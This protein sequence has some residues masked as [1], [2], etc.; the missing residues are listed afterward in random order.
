M[1]RIIFLLAIV[2]LLELVYIVN[3]ENKSIFTSIT[4]KQKLQ[5]YANSILK[6]CNSET[7]RPKCYDDEIPKF[8]DSVSMEDAFAVTQIIQSKDDTYQY[9]HVLA[10]RLGAAETKKNPDRWL[11]IIPRCP[12]NGMCSY[13]C[14]HGVL[15]EKFRTDILADDQIKAIEGDLKEACEAR[16]SWDPTP[17]D[18]AICYHGLGHLALYITDASF[19]KSLA[20]CDKIAKKDDGRD[21]RALC[22]QGTFMQLFQP[23]EPEDEALV[24]NKTPAKDDL[25][26]FCMQFDNEDKREACWVE[27]WPLYREEIKTAKGIVHFCTI[28]S[29]LKTQDLCFSMIFHTVGQGNNFDSNSIDNVCKDI[30]VERRA[31]C[32]SDGA[33]S[34]IQADKK[35]IDRAT[36]LCSFVKPTDLSDDCYK[37]LAS[38]A[39]YNFH[40]DSEDF[41]HFCSNLPQPWKGKCLEQ[42]RS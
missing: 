40:P 38:L 39:S 9:C 13:G 4:S 26:S 32:Y 16:S 12:A 10:H 19:Y 23:L 41:N 27:G 2:I 20:I 11:D 28:P 5:E 34:M 14:S 33:L 31:E 17:I 36:D 42:K 29:S 21:L 30:P 15:Q 35:F 8:M 22:Y 6:K 37:K 25:M 7:Y 3:K 24:K 1:R 18:Q